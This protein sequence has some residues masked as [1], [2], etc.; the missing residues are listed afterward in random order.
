MIIRSMVFAGS[1]SAGI[2]PTFPVEVVEVES[3]EHAA[4]LAV[5][6]RGR[7]SSDAVEQQVREQERRE[8]VVRNVRFGGDRHASAREY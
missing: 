6:S 1:P 5:E 2:G 7:R 3:R 4:S 8:M